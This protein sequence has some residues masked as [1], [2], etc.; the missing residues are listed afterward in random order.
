M[1]SWIRTHSVLQVTRR[2]SSKE[3][4]SPQGEVGTVQR[5]A[6]AILAL[7]LTAALV[8]AC[9]GDPGVRR[10]D[11]NR[12]GDSSGAPASSPESVL[13]L[14]IAMASLISPAEMARSYGPFYAYLQK[15]LGR[16]VELTQQRTYSETYDLLRTGSVDLALVCS[17]VYILGNKQFGLVLVAAPEVDGKAEYYSDII[18]RVDSGVQTVEQ[19]AGRSF[20]FS[21]PLSN[22]GRAYPLALVRSLGGDPGDFFSSTTFTYSHDRSIVAVADGLVDGAAVDSLVLDAWRQRYPD[23]AAKI[24]VIHRSPAFA[25][26]PLVASPRLAPEL[27]EEIRAILLGMHQ[28][29]EGQRVLAGLGMDRFTALTDA[30]FASVRETAELAGMA[31]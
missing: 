30:D 6:P 9:R 2:G 31:P 3:R 16:P 20:A 23:R 22:S 5:R 21:D 25:S 29:P 11:L 13:P 1:C 10:V 12:I 14:R 18:V 4:P 15:R 26:P 27:R 8:V 28:D 19:L 7:A 24:R 17:Y